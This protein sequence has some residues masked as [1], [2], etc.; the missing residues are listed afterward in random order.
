LFGYSVALS[1]D[2]NTALIGGYQDSGVGAAWMFTR[3]GATWTPQGAKLTGTSSG[4]TGS[5][6]FGF[7]VALS[8]D[9]NTALIGG[10][11]DNSQVGAAWVFTRSGSTWTP[12]GSKLTYTG[13]TG[14]VAVQFGSSV[15]LSAD[16]NTALIGGP[17][18]SNNLG[19]AWAFTRAGTTWTQ[20]GAKLIANDETGTAQLGI[21]VALAADGNTALIGGNNDNGG[22]GAAWALTRAG[23][24][25]TQPGAKLIASDETGSGFFGYSVALAAD[26]NTALIGGYND[27]SPCSQVGAAWAFAAQT[28]NQ[29]S[30]TT[31][32]GSSQNPTTVGQS[33]TFTAT[34]TGAS[35]GGTVNFRDG[36]TTIGSCGAQPLSGVS[37]TCTTSS[38]GAG[39]HGIT[40]VYSGDANNAASTSSALLQIVVAPAPGPPPATSPGGPGAPPR[41][42][43]V[44]AAYQSCVAGKV[45]LVDVY[46]SGG[47]VHL[48]GVAATTF[49]GQFV[50]FWFAGKQIRAAAAVQADGT[51]NATATMPPPRVRATNNARYQARIGAVSSL[52]L[53]LARRSYVT[54]IASAGG[55]VT[56]T[57]YITRPLA[58]P[59]RGLQVRH[60]TDCSGANEQTVAKNVKIAPDGHYT[61]SVPAPTG[62]SV[63]FYRLLTQVPQSAGSPRLHPTFTLLR[64]VTIGS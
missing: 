64:G 38:L 15:A 22:V 16:G 3:A 58:K 21:S 62:P 8:G 12:P 57:G 25:W 23:S 19:A 28:V 49:A 42:T 24:T 7:S 14:A 11:Y 55:K 61:V 10:N 9:G 33:V 43:N 13:A 30:T 29:A 63:A 26:A 6:R 48:F 39:S 1:A 41:V 18:D 27:C 4:E 45:R 53:K 51:F 56:I 31:G 40:A 2:G 44:G 54:S 37:A 5:G 17:G 32:L 34:V 52:N 20:Q 35:P 50:H 60:S 46:P 59:A 36:S 47:Q